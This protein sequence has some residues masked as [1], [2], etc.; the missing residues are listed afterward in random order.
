MPKRRQSELWHTKIPSAN[1]FNLLMSRLGADL[2]PT[3]GRSE[4]NLHSI[5]PDKRKT[6]PKRTPHG[7]KMHPN[8]IRIDMIIS[9]ICFS[10]RH[11]NRRRFIKPLKYV[12]KMSV[13]WKRT[14]VYPEWLHSDCKVMPNW[15]NIT[16]I[17]K[18][19]HQSHFKM[20]PKWPQSA[21]KWPQ[22]GAKVT[23]KWVMTYEN[24]LAKCV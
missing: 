19:W 7:A 18:K 3:W 11:V 1:V 10:I 20:T 14:F 9:E 15:T 23:S 4:A 5:R 22:S 17:S 6:D 16:F 21:P 8:R 2:G 12:G 24:P 13:F